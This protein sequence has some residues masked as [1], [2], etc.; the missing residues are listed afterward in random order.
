VKGVELEEGGRRKGCFEQIRGHS[1]VDRGTADG[2]YC[3][4]EHGGVEI[5]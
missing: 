2:G 1:G 5:L 3:S 4:G